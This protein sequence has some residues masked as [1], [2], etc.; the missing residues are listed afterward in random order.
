MGTKDSLMGRLLGNAEKFTDKQVAETL[1]MIID[2]GAKRGASDIHIEPHERFVLVRY[3]IDGA[4]RGIHKLPRASLGNV[5]A[6]LKTLAGLNVRETRMPQEG[7]YTARIADRP[8]EVRISIM[9]VYGGEK[10]VL[11]LPAEHGEP[12]D[13]STLGFWGDGLKTLKSV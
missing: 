4:L 13:L 8:A 11:H 5:M 1:E 7:E 12:E 10:A 9:P 3:R 6:Q 2:Q